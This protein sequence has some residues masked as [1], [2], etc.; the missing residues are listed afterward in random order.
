MWGGEWVA[1]ISNVCLI[2]HAKMG[3]KQKKDKKKKEK[4]KKKK[5]RKNERTERKEGVR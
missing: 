1:S 2:T 4:K 3:G 5:E